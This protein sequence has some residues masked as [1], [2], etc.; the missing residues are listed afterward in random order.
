MQKSHLYDVLKKTFTKPSFE[1]QASALM[2][3]SEQRVRKIS[4]N[5]NIDSKWNMNDLK[6]LKSLLFS[7]VTN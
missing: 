5:K 7:T 4:P 6:N 1:K 2:E 3:K